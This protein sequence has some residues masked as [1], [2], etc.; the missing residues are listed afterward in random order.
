LDTLTQKQQAVQCE[1]LTDSG[2]TVENSSRC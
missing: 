2:Q 1:I